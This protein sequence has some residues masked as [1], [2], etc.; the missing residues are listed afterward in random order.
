MARCNCSSVKCACVIVGG[1]GASVTGAGRA[2]NPYVVELDGGGGG[3]GFDAGDVKWS[4]RPSASAG[5]LVCDGAPVSRTTYSAL[6]AAIGTGYGAG[7]GSTTFNLPD[8]TGRFVLGTD[9]SHVRGSSG[10]AETR[11][12]TQANMPAHN[13]TIGHNHE[14]ATTSAA[15]NHDHDLTKTDSAGS[16]GNTL[17][18]GTSG[19][20]SVG[21]GGIA[22][23]GN[24][25]HTFD[26]PGYSGVSGAGPGTSVPLS[27]M[28]PYQ[29]A[30]PLI[31]T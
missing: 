27:V 31:K 1:S 4:A 30:L 17:S 12:I 3:G 26:V 9:G 29:T 20:T 22:G 11:A 14:A 13:H 16:S 23:N 25:Q 21:G 10:G 28:P 19:S 18:K 8:F 15:G 7:D 5:W 6:F 24:H 2:D